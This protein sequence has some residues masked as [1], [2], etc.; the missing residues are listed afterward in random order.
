METGYFYLT[1]NLDEYKFEIIGKPG[2]IIYQFKLHEEFE[3]VGF[4]GHKH[5]VIEYKN[6]YCIS[7]AI[8]KCF[9]WRK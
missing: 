6:N 7:L 5:K 1:K 9:S 8:K 3:G 4:D 2:N